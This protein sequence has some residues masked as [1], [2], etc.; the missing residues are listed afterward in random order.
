VRFHLIRLR[1]NGDQARAKL[2]QQTLLFERAS[3]KLNYL[4]GM[5][6]NLSGLRQRCGKPTAESGHRTSQPE[7]HAAASGFCVAA[8][9]QR[10]RSVVLTDAVKLRKK[11]RREAARR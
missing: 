2:R 10:A 7:R 5:F 8:G 6:A 4:H 1:P 11:F 9:W 3:S